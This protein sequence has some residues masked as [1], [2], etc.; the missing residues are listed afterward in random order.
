MGL[1]TKKD[2][3]AICG[4]KVKGLFAWKIDGQY[5]CDDCHGVI[6]VPGGGHD[7]SMEQFLAY[8]AFREENQKLKEIFKVSQKINFGAFDTKIVFDFEHN[9]FCMDQSLNKTIFKGSEL[10]SF[11]IRE[12]MSDLYEGSPEGF[13]RY[14]SS[15]PDRIADITPQ[16]TQFL[17]RQ[18]L[19]ETLDR[20]TEKN[21]DNNRSDRLNTFDIPEP[22]TSFNV[23]LCLDHP[24]W[25]TIHCDKKG[26][27]FNDFEP[28]VNDYLMSYKE[29]SQIMEQLALA[30]RRVAFPNAPE[31]KVSGV[32]EPAAVQAAAP[33]V[34]TVTEIKK[35]KALLEEGVITEEEF[36]A[37]KKQL[38]GL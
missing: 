25:S 17:A 18:Q 26:P 19:Q 29:A 38:M 1:F 11:T 8:R 33:A 6:D 30:L 32:G 27:T 12:D 10:H 23:D 20:L 24:Y 28:N 35:Y 7:M 31:K 21:G 5:V 9:L 14:T 16:V 22:F 3:C 2:P 15:V 36:A 37:K 4:G 34:D 13:V